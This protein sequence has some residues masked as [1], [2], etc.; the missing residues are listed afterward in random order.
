[1]N[2][3]QQLLNEVN[4]L[5]QW[6]CSPPLKLDPAITAF[7]QAWADEM[8]R[9][10]SLEF[11]PANKHF[12]ENLWQG[13]ELNGAKIAK[14]WYVESRRY[15]FAS[16]STSFYSAPEFTQMVWAASKEMGVGAAKSE[17]NAADWFAV[18]YFHPRS[19]EDSVPDYGANVPAKRSQNNTSC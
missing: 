9:G 6:H 11:N 4:R 16:P 18:A 5:R 10:N 7:A 12:S 14:R 19:S 2:L 8:A 3:P 17:E 1:M 13:S 15:N